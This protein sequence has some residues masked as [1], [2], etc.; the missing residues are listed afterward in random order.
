MRVNLN[1][2]HTV[3]Y[4]IPFPSLL[5]KKI[6]MGRAVATSRKMFLESPKQLNY[7]TGIEKE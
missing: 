7:C 1:I 2:F 4:V 5:Q 3:R 6:K